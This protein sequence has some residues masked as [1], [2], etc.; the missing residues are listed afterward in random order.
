MIKQINKYRKN[1]PTKKI[2]SVAVY[3]RKSCQDSTHDFKQHYLVL[4][5]EIET[6]FEEG[7]AN[8][9]ETK[10]LLLEVEKRKLDKEKEILKLENELKLIRKENLFSKIQTCENYFHLIDKE[11][12]NKKIN[13]IYK[14]FIKEIVFTKNKNEIDIKINFFND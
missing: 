2:K 9:I 14:T 4:I 13:K 6:N 3:L 1:L 8:L 12:E 10:P 5:E 7:R 11:T